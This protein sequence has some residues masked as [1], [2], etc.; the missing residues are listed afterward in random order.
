MGKER[1]TEKKE[2]ERKVKEWRRSAD[3]RAKGD[4]SPGREKGQGSGKP[5]GELAVPEARAE[6]ASDGVQ[7]RE[8]SARGGERGRSVRRGQKPSLC[9][10]DTLESPQA[11]PAGAHLPADPDLEGQAAPEPEKMAQ[12]KT[13]CRSPVGLDCCNCCLDLAHRS[14]LQSDSSGENNNPGSPTVSN[15]RQL[16]EKLI[17][18]NLNTDKLNSIMRQDSL[19]PVL[20]DPCYLINEG[21]CN[22]N[23]DQTM[24][25]I[26]L[27]FHSA[28]GASVVAIDNKI[29]Q[30]MGPRIRSGCIHPGTLLGAS[31]LS[32]Q[33]APQVQP[34]L[35]V[36]GPVAGTR[37]QKSQF[38]PLGQGSGEESSDVRG[39]R[40]GGD[41]EGAD[42]RAGREELPAGARE[43]ALEDPGEPRAAGEVSVPSE[44]RG[45]GSRNPASARGPRWFCGVSGSVLRVGRATKLVLPSSFQFVFGSPSVISRGELYT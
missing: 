13:D 12:P 14:G 30:A 29:E 8:E 1:N 39:Q 23:I 16:Q 15:F 2:N 19:E 25:S 17:F 5:P 28:S 43:H 41:P 27:F 21:I 35:G 31:V 9:F 10:P 18:E 6:I 40:G 38:R 36:L 4:A 34:Q 26:L 11:S 24:L 20:R 22:R 7:G 32:G 37:L 3:R 45:A 44:P 33:A 42:P